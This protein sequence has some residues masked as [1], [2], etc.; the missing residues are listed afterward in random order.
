MAWY[1]G[2]ALLGLAD[3]GVQSQTY[4]VVGREYT[5]A[6]KEDAFAVFSVVQHLG[7]ALA[8]I[9]L[10]IARPNTASAFVRALCI[11][12]AVGLLAV[13]GVVLAAKFPPNPPSFEHPAAV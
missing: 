4:T 1:I 11:D 8:W 10:S 13:A 7:L 2:C 9:M 3:A 12:G 6:H 5:G